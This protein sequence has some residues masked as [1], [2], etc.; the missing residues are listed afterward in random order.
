MR[1]LSRYSI[2]SKD[3]YGTLEKIL[4]SYIKLFDKD[5]I[6]FKN[7]CRFTGKDDT[8]Y[9]RPDNKC[10][11]S[12]ELQGSTVRI[13][14][15]H[16]VPDGKELAFMLME[17]IYSAIN[18]SIRDANGIKK[19]KIF[20]EEDALVVRNFINIENKAQY[21]KEKENIKLALERKGE[22]ISLAVIKEYLD[23]FYKEDIV[24]YEPVWNDKSYINT[25]MRIF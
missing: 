6:D 15:N 22:G 8:Q 24:D 21:N 1:L 7:E 3:D 19:I 2:S 5:L 11:L 18:H 9:I 10:V 4:G 16:H 12:L 14:N 23:N 25:R 17:V 20:K 13:N